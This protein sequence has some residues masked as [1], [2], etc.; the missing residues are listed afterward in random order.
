MN[1]DILKRVAQLSPEKRELLEVLMKEEATEPQVTYVAPRTPV[2]EALANIWAQVL[3][4]KQVSIHD[5][6]IELGGDSIQSVKIA[7]RAMKA[8]IQL[9]INQIFEHLTIAELA[10]VVDTTSFHQVEQNPE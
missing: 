8:G 1:D 6:F 3:G 4:L 9:S 10:T 7:A 2:E 5:N